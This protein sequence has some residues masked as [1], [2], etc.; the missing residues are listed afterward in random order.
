MH[1]AVAINRSPSELDR[2]ATGRRISVCQV[3][4]QGYTI[5]GRLLRP[6]MVAVSKGSATQPGAKVDTTA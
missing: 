3:V 6:A 5:N 1:S 4:Q 2:P